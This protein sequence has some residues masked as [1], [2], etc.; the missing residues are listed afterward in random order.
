[1]HDTVNHRPILTLAGTV[2]PPADMMEAAR[3][4]L[5][6]QAFADLMEQTD[7]KPPT[8]DQLCK[9]VDGCRQAS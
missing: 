9:M 5:S 7:G 1:M 8:P 6:D 3:K 2:K 4:S